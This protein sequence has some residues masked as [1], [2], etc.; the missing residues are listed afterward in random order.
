MLSLK[1]RLLPLKFGIFNYEPKTV[2]GFDLQF[3]RIKS[4]R[5]IVGTPNEDMYTNVAC[6]GDNHMASEHP[7][8]VSISKDGPALRT[9]KKYNFRWDILCPTNKE[10]LSY[11]FNLITD[12]SLRSQGVSLSSIHFADHGFCVCKRCVE[13]H[14]KSGLEWYEWRKQVVM[15]FIKNAREL[16]KSRFFVGLLPDPVMSYQRFGIDFDALAKYADAFVVPHF[17]K[18]YATPWYFEASA[19]AFKSLLKKP[20]YINLYVH[21][22]GD[23]PNDVPTVR[24]VLITSVRVARTGVDGIIFLTETAD[25]IKEFQKTVVK[26]VKLREELEAYGGKPVLDLIDRWEK[27]L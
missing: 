11:I 14:K 24:E 17:S 5:G 13:E 4:E 2:E 20:V 8:W 10:Y 27:M 1:K 16:V 19:R 18:S 9:N 26:E 21:G 6:F 22:P 25:R 7:D 3:Y 12:V 23:K 15:D